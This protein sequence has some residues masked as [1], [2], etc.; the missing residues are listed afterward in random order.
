M[1]VSQDHGTDVEGLPRGVALLGDPSPQ[2]SPRRE[3]GPA[4][5]APTGP[6]PLSATLPGGRRSGPL[7][8]RERAGVRVLP[9]TA[10]RRSINRGHHRTDEEDK[11]R[12]INE[13][14]H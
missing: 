2:P 13:F 3:R 5:A 14:H 10:R 9:T 4:G 12:T 6:G 7:S 8:L 11:K 1:V